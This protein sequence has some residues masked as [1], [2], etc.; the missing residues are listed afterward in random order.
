M[1]WP[2]WPPVTPGTWKI[3]SRFTT[4]IQNH[5][6]MLMWA[7]AGTSPR[8]SPGPR[9]SRMVLR[10]LICTRNRGRVKT[11]ICPVCNW[12][13]MA[14]NAKR[15]HD[16]AARRKRLKDR[17]F[18]AARRARIRRTARP[19]LWPGC[20]VDLRGTRRQRCAEH[21]RVHRNGQRSHRRAMA[22]REEELGPDEELPAVTPWNELVRSACRS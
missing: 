18:S 3:V 22:R 16:C 19:C 6:V 4:V 7:I 1:D 13:P 21:A 20:E 10:P 15:C 11:V 12:A 14:P 5:S 8:P 9:A 2:L 17:V